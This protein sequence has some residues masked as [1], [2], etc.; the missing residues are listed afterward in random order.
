M[1]LMHEFKEFINK[2]NVIDLAVALVMGSAFNKIIDS[3]VKGVILPVAFAFLPKGSWENWT[4]WRIKVGAVLD[5]SLQFVLI[6]FVIFI[7]LKKFFNYKHKEA[8]VA[9]TPE[10]VLLLREIRDSLRSGQS[11]GPGR[12]P[13]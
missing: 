13:G 4:I 12:P 3:L 1:K 10:D 11:F 7:V 6:A 8:A 5:A 9:P 2:G